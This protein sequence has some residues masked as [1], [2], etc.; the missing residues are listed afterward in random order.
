M[1]DMKTTALIVAGIAAAANAQVMTMSWTV[2]DTGN[3]D[4][5]IEAGESAVLTMYA[6]MD[7]GAVGYAGSIFDIL[8]TGNWD[9]G[10]VDS[11]ANLVDSL[12]TGP[13][14]LQGNNDITGIESFQLPPFFNPSFNAANPVAIYAITWTPNDY[15][16]RTVSLTSANHANFSVYTDTFGTSVEYTGDVR[17]GS[18][19]VVPAPASLALLGLGGLVARRRR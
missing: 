1:I 18:F 7:P 13:G 11:F 9:T 16:N 3:N 12:A 14:D 6:A 4:G 2:G 5:I 17:G 19:Q 10:S 8:G 15:S